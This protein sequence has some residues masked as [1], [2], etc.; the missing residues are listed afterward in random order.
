MNTKVEIK[1]KE[2][3]FRITVVMVFVVGLFGLL[4]IKTYTKQISQ[5]QYYLSLANDQHTWQLENKARRGQ[6]YDSNN[7]PLAINLSL[8]ALE[9]IPNQVED[10]EYAA[11][12]L[13]VI[14][15]LSREEELDLREKLRSKS[16]YMPP[17]KH[18]LTD[19]EVQEIKDLNL[20]GV[21][22]LPEDWRYYPEGQL[23]SQILGY[24]NVEGKGQ[25]GIEGY[26]NDELMGS[27]GFVETYHDLTGRELV[28]S[29]KILSQAQQ[30]VNLYLTLDR[31]VQY[32]VEEKLK[33]AVETYKADSG[34]VVVMDPKTG[35]IIAMANYP[36]FN[37]N[38][39]FKVDNYN[40]FNNS[41][42]ASSWEPGSIF[43]PLA[44]SMALDLG[45]VT[46]DTSEEFGASIKVLDREIF[47]SEK[48]PYGRETMTQVLE[49]SDNVGMVWVGEKVGKDNFY[50][51]LYKFG[52]GEETGVDL[53]GESVG[54]VVDKSQVS[55]VDLATMTFGQGIAVTP[56]QITAAF[57]AVANGG[58][59]MKPYIVNKIKTVDGNEV[60]VEP[61]V[62][63]SVLSPEAARSTAAMMVS[64]VEKGH[65]K[66][67]AVKGYY[68][69]GKTGTAQ[70]PI[71]GVYDPSKTIGSFVGFAPAF[72]P[73]FVM[74]VKIDIP[75]TTEWAES[76]AAPTF[77]EIAEFLL[78]YYMVA[79]DRVIEE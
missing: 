33:N 24:L 7:Y 76:S 78:D 46:P 35:K 10:A 37:P 29:E 5:H 11:R 52:F 9:V 27:S 2:Q 14:L 41:A 23:A 45:L 20:D 61:E 16:L 65:G 72:D 64:V 22:L 57:G 1:S 66:Q 4:T 56:V 47:N 55:E 68:V 53:S 50:K 54:M 73:K 6:V 13:A 36:T 44:M 67:A 42:I 12:K 77:G 62:V 26:F 39:Y 17:L 3:Q 70:V 31:S 69:A 40:N 25:Y 60:D 59:L 58:Y 32:F 79:P 49:N 21:L 15:H 63:R 34:S 30:G 19:E 28:D 8:S 75:K 48:K 18:K 71:N 38:E 51:Y 43:K 74:L